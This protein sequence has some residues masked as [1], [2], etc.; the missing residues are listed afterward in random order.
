MSP[1]HCN[2]LVPG[3]YCSEAVLGLSMYN[4][5][6]VNGLGIDFYFFLINLIL[7]INKNNFVFL[8]VLFVCFPRSQPGIG[9][10]LRKHFQFTR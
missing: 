9:H 2:S 3:S 5:L 8:F 7:E 4:I 6:D 1:K 10:E